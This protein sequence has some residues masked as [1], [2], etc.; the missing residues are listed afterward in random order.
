MSEVAPEERTRI[1]LAGSRFTGGRL[2]IDSLPELAQYQNLVR[3][4]AQRSWLREHD[5]SEPPPADLDDA[6]SLVVV[7][8]RNTSADI[9]LALEH[10]THY[11]ALQ[12][13]ARD[14]TDSAIHAAYSGGELPADLDDSI[15]HELARFGATL[16]DREEI[17]LYAPNAGP[18]PVV[19]NRQTRA[20]VV[21][22]LEAENF[23][24]SEVPKPPISSDTRPVV[25]HVTQ[26]NADAHWFVIS[27]A[28]AGKLKAF[29]RN[30]PSII[31]DLRAYLDEASQGPITRV[32]GM[33]QSRGP[34]PWRLWETYS[35]ERFESP[36]SRFADTLY[37][38]AQLEP[39]WAGV[40]AGEAVSFSAL[41][42]AQKILHELPEN[43]G[44]D[45]GVF[46]TEDGGV[47]IEW[48]SAREVASVEI[49]PGASFELYT[50][51]AGGGA[52]EFRVTTNLREAVEFA[53]GIAQ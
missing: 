37:S 43:S 9:F 18:E 10:A 6:M 50:K 19:V 29:Y 12:E 45:P 21:E 4:M 13:A 39:G 36:E 17:E 41:D 38:L 49:T 15:K 30:N 44:S 48:A 16:D 3:L 47:L 1:R 52:S 11:A 20:A 24:V 33:L 34:Q 22:R 51:R 28:S 5:S 26:V 42:A 8:I 2:P 7:E 53:S 27:T 14:A 40:V 32:V 35:I 46:P 25:G 31:D 23:L